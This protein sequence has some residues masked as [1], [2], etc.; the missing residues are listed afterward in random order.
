MDGAGPGLIPGEAEGRHEY[1]QEYY[2]GEAEDTAE[3]LSLDERTEVP[4]GV[5]AVLKTKDI[6]PLEP[7][8]IENKYYGQGVGPVLAVQ[9]GRGREARSSSS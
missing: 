2:K 9:A 6:T 1:R 5:R 8:V 3:V 4:A 7:D